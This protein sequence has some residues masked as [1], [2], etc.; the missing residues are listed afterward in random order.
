MPYIAPAFR[1]PPVLLVK[2][3]DLSYAISQLLIEYVKGKKD[4][5]R[6]N[7]VV[8]VLTTLK[9]EFS[10]RVLFPYED[11]ARERNGDVFDEIIDKV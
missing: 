8:G 5:E 4:F 1:R 10:R 9:D 3:G 6:L 2:P 7:D 11:K